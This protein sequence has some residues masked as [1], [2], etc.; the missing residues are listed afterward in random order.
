MTIGKLVSSRKLYRLKT[1]AKPNNFLIASIEG[2]KTE[3]HGDNRNTLLNF[4][5]DHVFLEK[6]R[7]LRNFDG[8]LRK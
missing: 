4:D 1:S 8:K 2:A 3:R 6:H 5:N 7:S